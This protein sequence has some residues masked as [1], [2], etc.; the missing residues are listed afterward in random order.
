L[1]ISNA[2]KNAPTALILNFLNQIHVGKNVKFLQ[3]LNY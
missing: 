1:V 2:K 3:N